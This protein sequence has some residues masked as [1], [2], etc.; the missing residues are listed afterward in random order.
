MTI[1]Y[2]GHIARHPPGWRI[3]APQGLIRWA[4]VQVASADW[5]WGRED[6]LQAPG[7]CI[8]IPPGTPHTYGTR[9]HFT[10]HWFRASELDAAGLPLN[11]PFVVSNPEEVA[12]GFA[13]VHREHG[14]CPAG[15]EAA[16]QAHAQLTLVAMR[17]GLAEAADHKAADDK[18]LITLRKSLYECPGLPWSAA[19]MAHEARLSP[20]HFRARYRQAFGI[21]PIA[22]IVT[23]RLEH[24]RIRIAAGMTVTEASSQAGFHDLP[25]F[26]R[27]FLRHYGCTPGSIRGTT[28]APMAVTSESSLVS[29]SIRTT[30]PNSENPRSWARSWPGNPI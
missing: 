30:M 14:T 19:A 1:T 11:Q 21:S 25:Y 5:W 29:R 20:A 26:H 6:H 22:D 16:C 10:N 27:Q 13:N 23:A 17:R 8:I 15:W 28:T 2:C 7:M 4:V 24:A 12:A 18:P 3:D 9:R